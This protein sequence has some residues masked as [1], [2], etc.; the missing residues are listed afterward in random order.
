M[1]HKNDFVEKLV[2]AFYLPSDIILEKGS[3]QRN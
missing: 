1:V 2:Q 3:I